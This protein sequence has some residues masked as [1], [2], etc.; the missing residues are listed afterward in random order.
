MK[1]KLI[2]LVLSFAM[3]LCMGGTASAVEAI[4]EA[5]INAEA[6]A[7]EAKRAELLEQRQALWMEKTFNAA[8]LTSDQLAAIDEEMIRLDRELEDSGVHEVSLSELDLDLGPCPM[9]LVPADGNYKWTLADPVVRSYRGVSYE[10]NTLIA[11]PQKIGCPLLLSGSLSQHEPAGVAAG[12]LGVM[13]CIA[14]S[15]VGSVPIAGMA[16]TAY[17]ALAS[18]AGA[19]FTTSTIVDDVSAVYQ[20]NYAVNTIFRYVNKVGENTPKL[21]YVYNTAQGSQRYDIHS[22]TYNGIVHTNIVGAQKNSGIFLAPNA[23]AWENAIKAYLDPTG[24]TT[25]FL[26][27]I[28][29]TGVKDKNVITLSFPL[30]TSPGMMGN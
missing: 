17:N 23:S 4:H 1:R 18:F 15:A 24:V 12:L 6:D 5:R 2:A 19:A 8:D 16:V 11:Q 20:W 3:V 21:S 9:I 29:V 28:N 14:E 25:A 30:Y 27:S 10:I 13:G 26:W 22:V 7:I